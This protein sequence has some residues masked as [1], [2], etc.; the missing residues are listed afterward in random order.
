MTQINADF[1]VDEGNTEPICCAMLC[2]KELALF[3]MV[4][5]VVHVF[6]KTFFI[7]ANLR[8]L[9]INYGTDQVFI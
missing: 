2:Y 7:C 6:L 8:H 1:F 5:Y 3:A 4:D 9:R